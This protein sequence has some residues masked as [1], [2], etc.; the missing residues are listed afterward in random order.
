MRRITETATELARR[1]GEHPA[2][3]LVRYPGF[4]GVISFD[5][6]DPRAVETHTSGDVTTTTVMSS[7]WDST[8]TQLVGKIIVIQSRQGQPGQ[9]FAQL[10]TNVRLEGQRLIVIARN[11]DIDV[12]CTY[13]R[14]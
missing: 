4:S 2:V 1:L 10:E 7:D 12:S 13:D 14:R 9:K 5:V 3:E 11:Q 8:R 6:A